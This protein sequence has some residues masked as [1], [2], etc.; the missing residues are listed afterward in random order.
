M[1]WNKHCTAQLKN[2]LCPSAQTH[3]TTE[4]HDQPT[5]LWKS[6]ASRE[7]GNFRMWDLQGHLSTHNYF[8]FTRVWGDTLL[9]SPNLA[10]HANLELHRGFALVGS[11]QGQTCLCFPFEMILQVSDPLLCWLYHISAKSMVSC[12]TAD[13]LFFFHSKTCSHLN[14]SFHQIFPGNWWWIQIL[15]TTK[16]VSCRELFKVY[17]LIQICD[18]KNYDKPPSFLSTF[19]ATNS[20]HKLF[21]R[22]QIYL[23]K[24]LCQHLSSSP[25]HTPCSS[26][27]KKTC[28]KSCQGSGR[29]RPG[30]GA[31]STFRHSQN[32]GSCPLWRGA[33]L[34][35]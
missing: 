18:I 6:A 8:S 34:L 21:H 9:G 19:H 2:F 15:G 17:K 3:W 12:Q 35:S 14:K 20:L 33:T 27:P 5:A 25:V 29:A 10:V 28:T 24:P 16:R 32:K 26:V 1:D 22:Y 13:L 23:R 4:L 30:H 7:Q 31:Y 11:I